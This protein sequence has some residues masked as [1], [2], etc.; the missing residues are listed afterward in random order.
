MYFALFIIFAGLAAYLFFTGLK[1]RNKG[2]VWGGLALGLLVIIFPQFMEFWGE[3]LWFIATGYGQRFWTVTVAEAGLAVIAFVVGAGFVY[4][5]TYSVGGKNPVLRIVAAL[6]GGF[7]GGMWGYANWETLL[8]FWYRVSTSI[9]DPVIG[10]DTGFYLFTFPFLQHI[11]SLL[12]I[13]SVIAV[14]ASLAVPFLRIDNA[15]QFEPMQ[16]SHPE[17]KIYNSVYLSSAVL[18]LVLAFGKFVERYELMYSEW[19]AVHGPG[20]TDVNI[21]LP[22]YNIIWVLTALS[23]LVLLIPAIRKK[24]Q[25]RMSRISWMPVRFYPTLPAI[26]LILNFGVWFVVLNLVPN[27]FQWLRVEPNEITFEKPYIANNITFTRQAFHLDKVEE[28]EFPASETLTPKMV[29][30]NPNLFNNVRLWDWRALDAVY[31]QF[32]EIRLYYEFRDV[33]ID[34]YVIDGNYRQVMISARGDGDRQPAR[35]KPDFCKS[36][37]QIHP[38]LWRNAH[39]GE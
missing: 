15:L 1:Q 17:D 6:M 13:L 36:A 22:A 29:E 21:R 32:Q 28:K 24:L 2:K 26:F 20:W 7:F 8:K 18:I 9:T 14:M 16:N 10:Q 12:L 25:W 34:R 35:P 38:R 19:G 5:L 23:G 39:Y 33:D 30:Q 4:F 27:L 37:L 31:K 11:Y 3:M